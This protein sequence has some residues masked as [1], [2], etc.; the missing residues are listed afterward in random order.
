[1]IRRKNWGITSTVDVVG[2]N[3][4]ITRFPFPKLKIKFDGKTTDYIN[5]SLN[6]IE[7]IVSYLDFIQ[8]LKEIKK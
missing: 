3:K 7:I 8:A 4:E 5:L 2:I 6:D 1:M